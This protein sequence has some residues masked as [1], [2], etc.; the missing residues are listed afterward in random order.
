MHHFNTTFV[1]HLEY[2]INVSA[3][4]EEFL[5]ARFDATGKDLFEKISSVEDQLS[6]NTIRHL[7]RIAS[8]R[9]LVMDN[10]VDSK[11]DDW[12]RFEESVIYLLGIVRLARSE[13]DNSEQCIFPVVESTEYRYHNTC[14]K[15]S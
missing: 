14:Y 4:A 12:G 9:K 7:R 1:S 8:I 2:A 10:S 15:E 3:Q 6:D 5:K 13:A 11:I